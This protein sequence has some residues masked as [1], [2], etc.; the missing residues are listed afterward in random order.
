[1]IL[2]IALAEKTTS[3]TRSGERSVLQCQVAT[4]KYCTVACATPVRGCFTFCG[5]KTCLSQAMTWKEF[6]HRATFALNLNR[7]FYCPEM[8]T[9]IKATKSFERLS[10]D[11]KCPLPS[12]TSNTYLLVVVDQYPRFPFSFPCRNMLSSNVIQCLD[13]LCP[14]KMAYWAKNYVTILTRAHIEWHINEG[15]TLHGLLWS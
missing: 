11:L 10:L 9:S 5:R 15:R 3:P 8:G 14:T 13:Q 6:A 4:W 12:Q 1:M 2:S 7:K